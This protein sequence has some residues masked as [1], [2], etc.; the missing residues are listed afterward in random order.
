MMVCPDDARGNNRCSASQSPLRC[1]MHA[2]VGVLVPASDIRNWLV[3]SSFLALACSHEARNSALDWRVHFA[4]EADRAAS[5]TLELS[6]REGSCEKPGQ[7]V[8]TSTLSP[9]EET[10]TPEL[11][12]D[13]AYSFS[14]EARR[15]ALLIA[16]ACTEARLPAEPRIDTLLEGESACADSGAGDAQVSDAGSNDAGSAS[17]ANDATPSGDTSVG[18]DGGKLDAGADPQLDAQ[19]RD[20]AEQDAAP[21]DARADTGPPPPSCDC[22]ACGVPCGCSADDRCFSSHLFLSYSG[23][24]SGNWR[25]TSSIT[26]ER[27]AVVRLGWLNG[28][29]AGHKLVQPPAP[30][31]VLAAS[32][33]AGAAEIDAFARLSDG[34]YLLSTRDDEVFQGEPFDDDDL[35]AFEPLTQ[36]VTRYMDLGSLLTSVSGSDVD[37]DA[38]HVTDDGTLLFSVDAPVKVGNAT[39]GASD[40]LRLGQG[41]VERLVL[42]ADVWDDRDLESL[43]VNPESGHFLA[44]FAGNGAIGAG[45]SFGPADLVEL[46]FGPGQ[47]F[48]AGYTLFAR[49]SSEFSAAAGTL[50]AVHFGE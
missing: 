20:A 35:I 43:S 1:V 34:R 15:G 14:A 25:P 28:E 38:L 5:S 12:R 37:V 16:R 21:A 8:F 48:K 3:L 10:Q 4:C 9:G 45:V 32:S 44:S 50:S 40:L 11:L 30:Q 18:S 13:G 41:G 42:G 47:P 33:F 7:L 17:D 46:A 26:L 22:S 27:A 39:F 19:Q 24:G 31:V 49:G 6:I 29:S 23:D 36:S 2:S